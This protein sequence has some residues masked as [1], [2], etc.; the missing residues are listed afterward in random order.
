MDGCDVMVLHMSATESHAEEGSTSRYG[1][2]IQTRPA[3]TRGPVASILRNAIASAGYNPDDVFTTAYV[4]WLLPKEHRKKPK[5]HELAWARPAF[6]SEIR[7]VKP[8]V[9]VC[10]GK[11]VFDLL[12]NK[13][14][15][16]LGEIA[17]GWFPATVEGH[18]CQLYPVEN[19][20]VAL[21]K[22]EYIGKF[23]Q[24]FAEVA[25]GLKMMNGGASNKIPTDY[26]VIRNSTEL[27]AW[28]NEMMELKPAYMAMKSSASFDLTTFRQEN[29]TPF[30]PGEG[31]QCHVKFLAQRPTPVCVGL[32]LHEIQNPSRR[33]LGQEFHGVG[34]MYF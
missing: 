19:P 7:R 16:K 26:R 22:P 20:E 24:D 12:Y 30:Q 17:G 4:K 31:G 23:R 14:K 9:I 5:H 28:V 33:R 27:R 10:L 21:L 3:Y 29:P 11:P 25:S 18:E 15:F 8:K 32:C 13:H 34:R 6:E 2:T 1:N